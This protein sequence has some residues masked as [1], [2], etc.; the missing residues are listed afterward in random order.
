M[1]Q[2]LFHILFSQNSSIST[3]SLN[4]FHM[5]TRVSTLDFFS[6]RVSSKRW[7]HVRNLQKIDLYFLTLCNI[8]R[9]VHPLTGISPQRLL[10][11]IFIEDKPS[12]QRIFIYSVTSFQILILEVVLIIR[13]LIAWIW[14]HHR[15]LLE[16]P[17]LLCAQVIDGKSFQFSI[18]LISLDLV[19]RVQ[20]FWTRAIRDTRIANTNYVNWVKTLF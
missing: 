15:P 13:L 10:W 7:Y 6:Y 18:E 3:S 12:G 19:Q 9:Y 5:L 20:V 11:K 1:S 17:L 16:N 14:S 2:K 4:Y 8:K